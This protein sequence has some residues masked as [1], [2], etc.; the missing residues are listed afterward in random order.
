MADRFCDVVMKGGVTS[1]IV[2]PPALVKLASQFA[3]KNIGGTSVGALAAA[4]AAA[5][6][7]R[8]R[9]DGTDDGYV[10]LG[11][12]A[13]FLSTAGALRA[14]F[15]ADPEAAGIL[16][17]LL[18]FTGPRSFPQ[19]ASDIA[20][21]LAWLY[22]W[23]IMLAFLVALIAFV[24]IAQPADGG[25][26]L[27]CVLGAFVAMIPVAGVAIAI[28]FGRRVVSVI[29]GNDFGFCH[30]HD[31]RG[32]ALAKGKTPPLTDWL[33]A[34][35]AQTAGLPAN[36]APLTFGD[37]WDAKSPQWHTLEPGERSI[38]FR[39]VTTC[40]TLGRPFELPFSAQER[41]SAVEDPASACDA[42]GNM[43]PPIYFLERDLANFF[44]PHIIAHLTRYGARSAIDHD[45][46]RLPAARRFPII[47][48]ARLSMS[49]PILFCALP[50]YA[51]DPKGVMQPIWFSDGGLS[52]NFPIHLFDS[53]LPRWPT[54]AID[55]V[56]GD[57][58]RDP[59]KHYGKYYAA[60]E[61]FMEDALPFGTV[62]PW[63]RFDVG[64]LGSVLA[65][66]MAIIDTMRTWQDTTL[67]TLPGNTSRT[68]GIRLSEDE[69]GLNLNMTHDQI[70]TLLRLGG[71]AG[72][73]LVDAFGSS[74]DT[75]P[76]KIHRLTRYRATMS[77]ISRW[78]D[79][80]ETG[81]K[82]LPKSKQEPYNRLIPRLFGGGKKPRADDALNAT[83]LLAAQ[84]S[85]WSA[86]GH[87]DPQFDS[88]EP[89]PRTSL[90]MRPDVSPEQPCP[91]SPAAA[92]H[93]DR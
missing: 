38:D 86:A 36:A 66:V 40:L 20:R 73:T 39:M 8:R 92:G 78:L 23:I 15:A 43:R 48:A 80:F 42:E 35:I 55:L 79:G 17:I 4:V 41:I 61:V 47:V 64:G 88:D 25:G 89:T 81:L 7:Y 28:L 6:E 5:A 90:R 10:Q 82:P 53:P 50:L 22:I 70:E 27:R 93:E 71:T 16:D 74:D 91:V 33:D 1:G 26:W 67:G 32:A 76:W 65:F 49:F 87:N 63:S 12:L 46:Y 37:L 57:P 45:Y 13:T 58:N 29:G 34:F 51:P 60:D 18:H 44:P 9:Q 54:F 19:K 21:A 30:G 3:F 14:L 24:L 84:R 75:A 77:A 68:V 83:E 69:G 62:N 56:G 85:S 52:S 11:T 72:E 31:P 59:K 2:Y